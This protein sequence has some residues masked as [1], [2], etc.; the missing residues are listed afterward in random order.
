MTLSHRYAAIATRDVADAVFELARVLRA[1]ANLASIARELEAQ[2]F[3]SVRAADA[4]LLAINHQLEL[5]RKVSTHRAEDTARGFSG[6]GEH[7]KVVRITHEVKAASLQFLV[8]VI[9]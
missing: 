2:K 3:D 1:D 6:L 8:Q 7:Q 9:Q 4:A 5:S